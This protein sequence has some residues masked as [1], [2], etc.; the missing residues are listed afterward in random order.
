MDWLTEGVARRQFESFA[1]GVTDGLVRTGYLMT[2]DLAETED[3]VQETL[4][5]VAR[6]WRRVRTMDHPAAYARRILVNLVI[7]G[8]ERRRRRADEL[9]S[10]GDADDGG[11]DESAAR[12][13]RVIDARSEFRLALSALTPRQRAV[14]VLRY[15]EDLSEAQVAEVLDCSVGTVKSTA[16]RGVARL[17]QVL[18]G[19]PP[20]AKPGISTTDGRKSSPC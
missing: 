17:R 11:T 5:R 15:W 16:S 18:A 13:L 19:R 4:L 8:H 3:L 2:G 7:D 9:D 20:S 1:A 12:A 10:A 6:R 14:V